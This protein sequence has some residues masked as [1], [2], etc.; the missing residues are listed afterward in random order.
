MT[1][2]GFA[3][4]A[5]YVDPSQPAY[6]AETVYSILVIYFIY[7]VALLA[8]VA[9][10]SSRY[11]PMLVHAVDV[12]T[13]VLLMHLTEGPTSPF[14]LFFGFAL[15]SGTLQWNS[16]GAIW[17][18]LLLVVPLGLLS[19]YAIIET[20][21]KDELNRV[22]MRASYLVVAGALLA[23][24]GAFR[25]RDRGRLKKL[26]AWP[27]ERPSASD[28]IVLDRT[29]AHA[30]DILQA[31][32][33]AV[34]WEDAEEPFWYTAYWDGKT[35]SSE[36]VAWA[37]FGLLTDASQADKTPETIGS[38]A[39]E[40]ASSGGRTALSEML[41]RKFGVSD[42]AAAPLKSPNYSGYVVAL[43]YSTPSTGL[44]ALLAIASDRIAM[45]LEDQSLRAQI[46]NA[47]LVRER[48]EIAR[49]MHD[50]LLQ[51][52]TA[53]QLRLRHAE[54]VG[55]VDDDLTAI[56]QILSRQQMRVRSFVENVRSQQLA[57]QLVNLQDEVQARL[58]E[59]R[60]QWDRNID[61]D[62]QLGTLEVAQSFG[63]QVCFILAEAIANAVKHG[64]ATQI[65][66]TIGT[67][68]GSIRVLIRDNG[69]GI[70]ELSGT[71]S[72]Q[73]ISNSFLGPRMVLTRL[74]SMGGELCLT[75]GPKGVQLD[76]RLPIP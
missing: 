72:H 73:D 21:A 15:L 35:C 18:T 22:I 44:S 53:A 14:F 43:D 36:R 1:L 38:S 2:A 33:M 13:F 30:A 25:E 48:Q 75:S 68:D 4:L 27:Q 66:I 20:G 56:R 57:V 40:S 12:C 51:D 62:S 61:L 6:R 67:V 8:L 45:Q 49:D 71:Y 54:D 46:A 26:A 64:A 5:I 55:T 65:K 31:T 11:L 50:G 59:L 52:L 74:E 42:F 41:L 63:N 3:L 19:W 60:N 16:Q 47:A 9:D 17:T 24:V 70:A 23:Y 28:M 10:R 39:P 76:L 32:H 58:S 7:S 29:L 34:V 37:E 69:V